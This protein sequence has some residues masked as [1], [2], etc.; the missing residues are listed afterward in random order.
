MCT[1]CPTK[2]YSL[3]QSKT[4]ELLSN[5]TKSVVYGS[6][7]F[8]GKETKDKMCLSQSADKCIDFKFLSLEKG[9]GLDA[10]SDGI[11]GL[12]PEMSTDR[13]DQHLV[14]SLMQQGL[15]SKASFSLSLADSNSFAIFG[16]VDESQVVGGRHGL[17]PFRNNPDI[18]SHIKAWALSGKGLY[19]G[20]PSLGE[21]GTYPAVIDTGS[22]LIA[23][24]PPLFQSL[25]AKWKETVKDLDCKSDPNFC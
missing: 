15:I 9:E 18:F 6:A 4:H 8:A 2:P 24:P 1:N 10:E 22:T 17:R 11:L 23:V 21:S 3:T 20:A 5:E 25:A 7:K 13:N 16:G 14:W 12:S 19:Y